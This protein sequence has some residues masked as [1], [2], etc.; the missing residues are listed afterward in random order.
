MGPRDKDPN[1][2]TM[3]ELTREFTRNKGKF[4]E[5]QTTPE[6]LVQHKPQEQPILNLQ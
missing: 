2:L 6:E 3:D 1:D 5:E 4:R